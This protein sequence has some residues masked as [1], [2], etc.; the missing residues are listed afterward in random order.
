[1]G[2]WAF[3]IQWQV[4]TNCARS[5]VMCSLGI[6]NCLVFLL[7]FPVFLGI[8]S[9]YFLFGRKKKISSGLLTFIEWFLS[10]QHAVRRG[11]RPCGQFQHLWCC[12][13]ESIVMRMWWWWFRVVNQ[14]LRHDGITV[15]AELESISRILTW[16]S[17]C[18]RCINQWDL[19]VLYAAWCGSNLGRRPDQSLKAFYYDGHESKCTGLIKACYGGWF[20]HWDYGCCLV[21]EKEVWT[22]N[23]LMISSR[24]AHALSKR[25]GRTSSSVWSS[26][27]P[28]S[29]C[30]WC[31]YGAWGGIIH[32]V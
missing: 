32:P 8:Y 12:G 21:I 23:M 29:I 10:S 14:F 6:R 31:S 7:W 4:W 9:L 2:H 25:S 13:D 3:L 1:M 22:R 27:L 30:S 5:S 19:F 17:F 15:I 20:W 18:S 11:L 28:W 24:L 16:V 26:M